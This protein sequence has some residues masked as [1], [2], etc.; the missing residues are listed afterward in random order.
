MTW[1]GTYYGMQHEAV[2]IVQLAAA[3]GTLQ[4]TVT[5]ADTTDP[6]ANAQVD[7][8]GSDTL[9]NASGFYQ[10]PNLPVGTYDVTASAPGY[11]TTTASG[12]PVTAGGTTVQ[13][14]ALTPLPFS[15]YI[16]V[17]LKGY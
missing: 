4:G 9:T 7:A 12:V 6:I 16:P 14:F 15:T 1:G 5:D 10:F 11:M 2:T 13:D 17:G 3:T 8:D